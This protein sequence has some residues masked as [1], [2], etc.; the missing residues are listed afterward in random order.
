MSRVG[1]E[2]IFS[3]CSLQMA[4]TSLS[5]I[6][7]NSKHWT[8]AVYVSRLWHHR[9]GTDNG[10]IKHT[11][12]VVLDSEVLLLGFLIFMPLSYTCICYVGWLRLLLLHEGQPHVCRDRKGLGEPVYGCD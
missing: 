9:G 2:L 6:H 1:A 4:A 8:V 12:L 7:N 10:P 3:L 11:D 5:E